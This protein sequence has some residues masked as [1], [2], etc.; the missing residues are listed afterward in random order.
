MKKRLIT[1]IIF[2]TSVIN[3]N[4]LELSGTVISDNEKIITSRYM[5]FIEKVYVSEG[6]FVKKGQLLYKIDSSNID[7]LKREAQLNL[8]IQ[9]NN[10]NNVKTNYERYKR[11]YEKDLVPK[12]DVEQLELKLKNIKNMIS[13][14]KAKLKEVE[15]QYNY[16]KI[17]APNDGL[18]I[19]KSI[20]SGEMAMP[21]S[22]A[23][24]LS[25]LN[26]LK[27]KTDISESNLRKIKIGKE[28]EIQIDSL[29]LN[30]KGKIASIIP[31]VQNMTHSFTI[32]ISFDS[33]GMNIYPGMYSK[34]FIKVDENGKQ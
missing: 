27:I 1:L 16:L 4:A 23:I 14:A 3:L 12:Y 28:V 24:I 32:K 11:L 8:Q 2:L 26:S 6:D 9:E 30:T 19:K 7:S 34:I 22:P 13:I 31:N 25:D 33:K 18:V 29:N 15:S 10:Y 20:K 5:G 21:S 17:V